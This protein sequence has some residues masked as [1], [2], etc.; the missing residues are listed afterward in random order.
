MEE[1]KNES[2]SGLGFESHNQFAKRSTIKTTETQQK[3]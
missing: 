2:E 1:E 3:T